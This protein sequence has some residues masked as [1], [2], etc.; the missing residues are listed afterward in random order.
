[1]CGVAALAGG[2]AGNTHAT[3][4]QSTIVFNI[5]EEPHSLN[6][7]LAQSDDELQI[8]HLMFDLL[9]DVDARGRPFPALATQVPSVAN[10]GISPDGLT[11]TYR[12]RRGVRWQ[13]GAPFSS[14][15]VRFTW[16]AL[17]DPKNEVASTRGYDLIASIDTPDPL[18]AVIH[19]KR[20]WAPAV[21]T[22][23]TYGV[24]PVPIV[25]AHLLE[26]RGPM[27]TSSFN[28]HPVGTGPYA[29]TRWERG[30]HLT[31]AANLSYFRSSPHTPTIIVREV[32][33]V[34]TDLTMLR[35]GDL[36]WS[37]LSP[38]QRV[39]F[40]SG[41]GVRFVFAPFSGFAAMA[42]N[43]RRPPFDEPLMRRAIAAAIDRP[44]MSRDITHGQYPV[45]ETDQPPFS[46]AYDPRIRQQPFDPAGADALLDAQGW[47]RGS[48]G[49][50][51]K[52][53]RPLSL[54][55]ATFPEGDTAVR[56]SLYVQELL[57]SRGI[58]VSVKKVTVAQFYLP[59]SEGGLL[60]SGNF[61]LAYLAWRTGEDPDDSDLVTC[62]G[63]ANFAG[64]CDA[65][66]DAF[67]AQALAAT[68][69]ARR[70]LAYA[71]VQARLGEALPYLF[72]FAPT[73]GYALRE[74]VQGLDPT[75][76][77]P[78]WNSYAWVKR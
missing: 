58:A 61:D 78:T 31:F 1:M 55:F 69:Q 13:D 19:L 38:A 62:H 34:N 16:Q 33:D 65:M 64:Y 37:L 70:K 73:Y 47:R 3:A 76:F 23:F 75:P 4:R 21:A 42:F 22:F 50:R 53:G 41:A 7:L 5:S 2:C 28:E 20:P 36:D 51:R 59:K 24:H 43:C 6:P 48:D 8:A 63:Y 39:G 49:M 25:P 26:G 57:R 56:T 74:G 30:D 46:W 17:I 27:R 40:G 32:P 72:L 10:G 14:H 15:D 18:T 9:I 44:R 54:V 66:I 52:D 68:T 77:S 60:M 29:L 67:E 12:L 71:K 45:A 11:I 35:T